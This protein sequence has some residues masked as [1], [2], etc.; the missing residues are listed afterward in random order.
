MAQL[1][2]SVP[3]CRA[4]PRFLGG[5]QR[6]SL[7]ALFPTSRASCMFY[8]FDPLMVEPLTLKQILNFLRRAKRCTT[9]ACALVESTVYFLICP[10]RDLNGPPFLQPPRC[11]LQRLGASKQIALHDVAALLS[12]KVALLLSFY[13]LS[14]DMQTKAMRQSDGGAYDGCAVLVRRD[15][16]YEG[17]VDFELVNREPFEVRQ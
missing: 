13:T 10:L 2:P 15:I 9:A 11:N 8:C 12:Q 1:C 17:P 14:D 4:V 7:D 5:D 3:A 6:L 16:T